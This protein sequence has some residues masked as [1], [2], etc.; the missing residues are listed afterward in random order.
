MQLSTVQTHMCVTSCIAVHVFM[1]CDTVV[2][3][4]TVYKSVTTHIVNDMSSLTD[5]KKQ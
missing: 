2:H 4:T 5:I 1:M 3:L